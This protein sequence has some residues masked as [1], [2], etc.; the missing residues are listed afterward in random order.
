MFACSPNYSIQLEH[1][2]FG[3]YLP[4]SWMS[5]PMPS[6][7]YRI[8]WFMEGSAYYSLGKETVWLEPGFCYL[9]PAHPQQA[10]GCDE[11]FTTYWIH[12]RANSLMLD[13]Q[14]TQVTK[15]HR[16]AHKELSA[17]NSVWPA[18]RQPRDSMSL[19]EVLQVQSLIYWLLGDLLPESKLPYDPLISRL[20][21]A[22]DFMDNHYLENPSLATVAESAFLSPVYFHQQFSKHFHITSHEYMARLRIRDAQD[23]LLNTN[24]SVSFIAEHV[25]YSDAFYFS[26]VFKKH[27]GLSPLKFRQRHSMKLP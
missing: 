6:L 11:A 25:G 2:H 20:E 13:S 27:T 19:A 15:I 22:I 23:Y 3:T 12:F 26:R 24:E 1:T 18:L 5:R 7:S 17:F 16:W 14:L 21:P 4:E 9:I 10:F 8:Y